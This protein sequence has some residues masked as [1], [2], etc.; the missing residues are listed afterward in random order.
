MS[1]TDVFGGSTVQ[2]ADVQFR[3]VALSASIVTVWPA[4]A[5]TGN[6]CARIM[7]VTPSAGSLTVTLPDA[8]LTSAG[9]DIL[10][11]NP[12]A[13]TF[14]VLDSAGGVIATVDAGAV[15]YFYLS[16][17]STAAGTWRVT[18]FGAGASS[19]DAGQLAGYGLKALTSKL[20]AA[21]PVSTFGSNYS[22]VAADRAKVLVWTGGSGTLTLPTT[23][24]STSDFAF[25]VRNQGTGT[26]T[27]ATVGGVLI[28]SS[29]SIALNVS[30]SCFVHMGSADWYTVGRG[31]NTS[32]NFTQ[33]SKVVAG[34]TVA[35]TLSEASNVVQNYTGVLLSNQIVTLPAVVQVYYVRNN[36]TGAYTLT[37]A[38]AAGGTS[39]VCPALQ[40]L[41]LFCDGTNIVNANTTL[42]GGITALLFAAGSLSTPSV[43]LDTTNNGIYCP[44]S[45]QIAIS[46]GGVQGALFTSTAASVPGTFA[47]SNVTGT[48]TGDNSANTWVTANFATLSSPA[49]T[50][51]PTAPTA[52]AGTTTTQIATTA[53]VTG[54]AFVTALPAQTGNSGKFVTTDGTNASWANVPS[55]MYR[56]AGGTGVSVTLDAPTTVGG[57]QFH[58][59]P[60][61]YTFDATT[62]A[63]N[64]AFSFKAMFGSTVA[65]DATNNVRVNFT[66]TANA[67][68]DQWSYLTNKSI[69]QGLWAGSAVVYGRGQTIGA[70]NL[71]AA[72][73]CL[74]TCT[75]ANGMVISGYVTGGSTTLQLSAY[76]PSTGVQGTTVSVGGITTAAMVCTGVYVI[77]ATGFVFITAYHAIAGTVATDGTVTVGSLA[78]MAWTGIPVATGGG[79]VEMTSGTYVTHMCNGSNVQFCAFTISGTAI[80]MG[81][82]YTGGAVLTVSGGGCRGYMAAASSTTG[83]V[84]FCVGSNLSYYASSFTLAGT[85][86]T[87]GTLKLL[88]NVT[89]GS[90]YGPSYISTL[91]ADKYFA[92]FSGNVAG[93]IQ[94]AV[95]T[96]SG[97]VITIN[98]AISLGVGNANWSSSYN[99]ENPQENQLAY[100]TS[101]AYQTSGLMVRK[102]AADTYLVQ[103]ASS[104]VAVSISGTTTS[105]GAVLTS[106]YL[107]RA[108]DGTWL[109]LDASSQLNTITVSG[110]TITKTLVATGAVTVYTGSLSTTQIGSRYFVGGAWVTYRI[111]DSTVYFPVASNAVIGMTSESGNSQTPTMVDKF[112]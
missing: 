38:C 13:Y 15:K 14:S 28:D 50:G 97:G 48:N 88:F 62:L 47:A 44:A 29:A 95:L 68:A 101:C 17:S 45:N 111:V 108:V 58:V 91:A 57:Y 90:S 98:S 61:T 30:E 87:P 100:P 25:E 4:F 7:K 35:L 54:A 5:T 46:T 60:G 8:T 112:I 77:G 9:M 106:H 70:S 21:P 26:L 64:T 42:A 3:A 18:L 23:V 81:S 69:A 49:F 63:L 31:R 43:A 73:R 41:I 75:L 40:T 36:T 11:D 67:A 80:T 16:D 74:G 2:A 71:S 107:S 34:G 10:F 78:T 20:N 52:T 102:Y 110:N 24:G 6:Q 92:V 27:V 84:V 19:V 65:F 66:T 83:C 22:V 39:A 94:G 1:Y 93:Q 96:V 33:L 72:T 103:H 85:V 82:V 104:L 59:W 76:N 79:A 37:F 99:Y 56:N 53:F 32:F 12:G 89:I 51:T 105:P 109:C 86:V 55:G